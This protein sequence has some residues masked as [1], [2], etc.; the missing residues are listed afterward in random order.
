MAM[1]RVGGPIARQPLKH[2][3]VEFRNLAK[4]IA[5]GMTEVPRTVT[6]L[7]AKCDASSGVGVL[8]RMGMSDEEGIGEGAVACRFGLVKCVIY[9][10]W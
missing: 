8:E 5:A 9:G 7:M 1:A 2:A 3:G 10:R 4:R 6:V